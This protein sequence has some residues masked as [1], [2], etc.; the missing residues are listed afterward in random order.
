MTDH[1]A[2]AQ[3]KRIPVI[4]VLIL[5]LLLGGLLLMEQTGSTAGEPKTDRI[6]F[7]NTSSVDD[8]GVDFGN[9][10]G[11]PDKH[12]LDGKGED[13][14]HNKHCRGLSG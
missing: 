9:P 1:P 7:F 6:E 8:P 4:L 10:G 12:C 11:N 5:A 13:D 14:E 3:L 2:I